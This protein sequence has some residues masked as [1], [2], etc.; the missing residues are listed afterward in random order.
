MPEHTSEFTYR[1]A[2]SVYEW[3]VLRCS[4]KNYPYDRI[5]IAHLVYIDKKF[6][7]ASRYEPG[8]RYS[9]ELVPLTR[10]PS[11][12]AVQKTETL[13]FNPKLPLFIAKLD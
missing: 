10:Y 12:N 1:R 7:A 3:K 11:L 8:K 5:R 2:F 13:D 4:S 6:T 9:V